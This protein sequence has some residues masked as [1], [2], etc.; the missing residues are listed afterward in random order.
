MK[1]FCK[2]YSSE[3]R[4]PALKSSLSSFAVGN[5]VMHSELIWKWMKKDDG[6]W[7]LG[8]RKRVKRHLWSYASDERQVMGRVGADQVTHI[9]GRSDMSSMSENYSS[10]SMTP[11]LALASF[12]YSK[13]PAFLIVYIHCTIQWAALQEPSFIPSLSPLLSSFHPP[14]IP[15]FS[16]LILLHFPSLHS[17]PFPSLLFFLSIFHCL[18]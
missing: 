8:L 18:N 1:L 10:M 6:R 16:P 15:P 7:K 4:T 5:T 14:H 11:K 17:I 13:S 3:V 2:L 9:F 12:A